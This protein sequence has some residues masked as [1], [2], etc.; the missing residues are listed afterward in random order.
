M[1]NPKSPPPLPPR[2]RAHPGYSSLSVRD[3]LDAREAY[4]VHLLNMAHVVATAIGRYRIRKGDWYETHPP[5]TEPPK[6]RKRPKGPRTL[7]N[8]VTTDWSWPC[9]L[10]FVDQWVERADWRKGK[11]GRGLEPDQ[12]IPR[13][14]YL[15]DGRVVPTCVV[16]LE[17]SEARPDPPPPPIPAPRLSSLTWR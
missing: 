12:F 7:F 16:H 9:V 15:P 2:F 4:H 8:S 5:G 1:P 10:V 17:R 11:A 3:L 6:S 13:S 14:L